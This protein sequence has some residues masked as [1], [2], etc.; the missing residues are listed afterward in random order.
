MNLFIFLFTVHFGEKHATIILDCKTKKNSITWK[1]EEA[2]GTVDVDSDYE[3]PNGTKLIVYDLQEDQTGN[4][5]CWSDEGLE[6]YIYLLLDKS[7]E[8]S[9]RIM[10]LDKETRL[11][12]GFLG[13]WIWQE[14]LALCWSI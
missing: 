9:G 4:Y 14:F 12:L 1:R 13:V 6:D 11:E 8:A 3:K 7:K 5:T 10:F 2:H